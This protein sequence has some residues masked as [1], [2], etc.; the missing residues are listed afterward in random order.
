MIHEIFLIKLENRTL[1]NF[2]YL[3]KYAYYTKSGL[4]TTLKMIK[5]H[6]SQVSF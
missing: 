5:F 2:I 3:T 4:F 6:E 1:F